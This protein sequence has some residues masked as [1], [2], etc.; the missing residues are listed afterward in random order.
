MENNDN[1]KND[2][3]VNQ[4]GK[5]RQDLLNFILPG[6]P[7]DI[8]DRYASLSSRANSSAFG[9]F[10]NDIVV[11]DTETTG[12]SLNHDEL[13]QI[14]AAKMTKGEITDRF[15]TFV[16]PGKPIPE[17]IAHLTNIHD[18]DVAYAISPDEALTKL[19]SFVG[20]SMI[21]AHNAEFDRGFT[22]KH[23]AGYPLLENTWID[24]LDLAR[25]ALPRMTSHRLIDLVQA[26][27]A[28]LSTHRADNDVEATCAVFRIL[29]AAVEAMPAPLIREIASMANS[30]QW[31]TSVVFTHFAKTKTAR[32]T[33]QRLDEQNAGRINDTKTDGK[34]DKSYENEP[35]KSHALTQNS[36]NDIYKV[37]EFSLKKLRLARLKG[38]EANKK[39]KKINSS[40]DSQKQLDTADKEVDK[41]AELVFPSKEDIDNA[42]SQTGLVSTLYEE[43]EARP[44]QLEMAQAVR[45]AF[46]TSNNLM[47]EAGTGVG[48]SMAYLVPAA[49]TACS[50]NI[51]VGI[52]TKTNALLDQLLCRELPA[53][54]DALHQAQPLTFAALKGFAHYPCLRKVDRVVSEGAKTK[55]I[56]KT[57]Y[58]QAPAIAALL[59]YIEQTKYDDMDALKLDYRVLPRRTITT[60]SRECLK[61]KCPY[62]GTACFVHG[63]RRNAENANI[64]VTNH[65]L[66]FCDLAA[67]GGLLP[68][69][70]Y[71]VIDE[72]HNAE[73][74]I[75]KAFS[76]E[77]STNDLNDLALNVNAKEAS[78]N[79]FLRAQRNTSS[80]QP[81]NRAAFF[82]SLMSRATTAGM[83]F[84]ESEAEFVSHIKDLLL[85]DTD[86]K[87]KGYE[88][89]ELWISDDVRQSSEFKSLVAYGQSMAQNAEN[90]ITVAQEL[91]GYYEG[92]ESSSSYQQEI[93]TV[94]M[95]LKDVVN[96]VE[97]ILLKSPPDYVYAAKIGRK[98]NAEDDKLEALLFNVG[99]TLNDTL[100]KKTSSVVFTSATLTVGDSFRAFED[101]LGLNSSQQS[102]CAELLLD[103]SY[104]F[105]H[106]MTIYVVKDIP[107]PNETH[108][109]GVLQKFLARV[110]I[111]MQGSVLTL[112]TNRREME[113]CFEEV[114]PQLRKEDLRLACQKWGL[115]VKGLRDDFLKDEY[116]SLFALKSFWE[117]FD[118]PGATLK[119]VIIPKLPFSKPGDPL[120]CERASRDDQAW[121]RYVLP[122]A[123]LETKQAAGRLI[124]TAYD[125]G[126]LILADRR[127]I[128][129]AYGKAFLDSLPSKNIHF[130]SM[131]EIVNEIA[132]NN[133]TNNSANN[134]ANNK[135]FDNL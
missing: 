95:K 2:N 31:S 9:I 133:N 123:V 107:E 58:S 99:A 23:P 112:F 47:V 12:F 50:N 7:A 14:A 46:A 100:Y 83:S 125:R 25:I 66:L 75:R 24:S 115:S 29:L 88:Y 120:S 3:S 78:K 81:K 35:N 70:C 15:M 96:A 22:T 18:E 77:L 114:Q 54:A 34:A 85:F 63:A 90:L 28:P 5:K 109:L 26:F 16:N 116:L 104:D 76:I 113:K 111:A 73:S 86:K 19:V 118:A 21:V 11:L 20:S 64:V 49:F 97:T 39:S 17:D 122:A 105:D 80:K 48:K 6:T 45:Q 110:H 102:Q 106:N 59:S 51:T 98:N 130:C 108:Y 56:G 93:A 119:N 8:I 43:Y 128:S 68:S 44:E 117:G 1:Q 127:L 67:N 121:R 32:E 101:S 30:Q 52:A 38:K 126:I 27:N 60:T 124:R 92:I 62:Y 82:E 41:E 53:L 71:W 37:E 4:D 74:E 42:F 57:E 36:N 69:I 55:V 10:D 87:S 103:S 91:V 79:V 134:G 72:A 40:K 61:K 94:A 131:A 89:S 33:A 132:A 135:H 129:K 84:A 65:S 13:M